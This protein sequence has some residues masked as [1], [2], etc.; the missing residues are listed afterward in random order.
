M[1]TYT[2]P[3]VRFLLQTTIVAVLLFHGKMPAAIAKSPPFPSTAAPDTTDAWTYLLP[4]LDDEPDPDVLARWQDWMD[5]PLNLNIATARQLQQLPG[6]TL[7]LALRIVSHRGAEGPF[8]QVE[9]LKRVAT[10]SQD[11]YRMIVPFVHVRASVPARHGYTG[12]SMVAHGVA[13][14]WPAANRAPHGA[15]AWLHGG[16][17]CTVPG[18]AVP[19]SNASSCL[20]RLPRCRPHHRQASGRAASVGSE[21]PSIWR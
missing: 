11:V 9:D 6:V 20:E 8:A 21:C 5:A 14:P 10:L 15:C 7:P 18:L 17:R 19:L 16:D 13:S 2:L 3:A 12:F 4:Y 1:L